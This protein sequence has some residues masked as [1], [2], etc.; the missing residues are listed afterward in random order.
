MTCISA[1]SPTTPASSPSVT[2]S[3]QQYITKDLTQARKFCFATY[4][5]TGNH[6]Y[7]IVG[8]NIWQKYYFPRFQPSFP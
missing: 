5:D 6:P 8:N 1:G 7:D 2:N 3:T 4:V